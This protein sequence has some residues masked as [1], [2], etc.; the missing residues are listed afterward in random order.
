MTTCRTGAFKR[1][2]NP[3]FWFSSFSNSSLPY[4]RNSPQR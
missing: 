3:Q 2:T 4:C 1:M